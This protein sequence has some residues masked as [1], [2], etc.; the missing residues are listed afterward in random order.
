MKALKHW[1]SST[2][3]KHQTLFLGYL[4]LTNHKP[5]DSCY[6]GK[7]NSNKKKALKYDLA[8]MLIYQSSVWYK[9]CPG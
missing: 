6:C 9:S 3:V 5:I 4:F 7:A 1:S 8:M 2:S